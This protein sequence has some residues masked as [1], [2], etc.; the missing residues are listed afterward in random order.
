MTISIILLLNNYTHHLSR[1]R[2][3]LHAN[4][5]INSIANHDGGTSSRASNI[6]LRE[7]NT[8]AH[9]IGRASQVSDNLAIL[10]RR[11]AIDVLKGNV[12]EVD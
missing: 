10:A 12:G 6:D 4:I 1:A 5:S 8:R 2:L 11:S 3:A 9:S 7:L